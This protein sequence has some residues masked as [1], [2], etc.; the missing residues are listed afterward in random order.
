MMWLAKKNNLVPLLYL[1]FHILSTTT[2]KQYKFYLFSETVYG[3]TMVPGLT[4]QNLAEEDQEPGKK[5]K[6][7]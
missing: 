3:A 1:N 6:F 2:T 5:K 4:A 7:F